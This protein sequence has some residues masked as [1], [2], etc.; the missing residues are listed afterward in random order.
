[1]FDTEDII[2]KII[3]FLKDNFEGQLDKITLKKND[4]ARS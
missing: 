4:T 1:M 2:E 3:N